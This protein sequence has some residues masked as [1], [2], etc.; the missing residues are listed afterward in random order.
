MAGQ[1]L[2]SIT[3]RSGGFSSR[4]HAVELQWEGMWGLGENELTKTYRHSEDE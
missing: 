2:S 1:G 3:G 4:E